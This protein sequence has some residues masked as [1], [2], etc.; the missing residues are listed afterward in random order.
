MYKDNVAVVGIEPANEPWQNINITIVQDY[1][2]DCYVIV[3]EL[4]PSWITLFH[5]SFRFNLATWGQFAQ[6]CPNY[7]IDTHIYQAWDPAGTPNSFQ[8]NACENAATVSAMEAVGVPVVVGEWSLAT[9]NCAL[10]LNGYQ[11]NVPGYPVIDCPYITCPVSYMD[12]R[13]EHAYLDPTWGPEITQDPR[14]TGE[15]FVSYG[16]CP[17]DQ[18]WNHSD[19]VLL[20]YAKLF[21][22]DYSNHGQFMWNFRTELEPRWSY[23]EATA[24]GWLPKGPFTEETHKIMLDTCTLLLNPCTAPCKTSSETESVLSF[25][26][27]ANDKSSQAQALFAFV[28][29]GLSLSICYAAYTIMVSVG[30]LSNSFRKG[31]GYTSLAETEDLTGLHLQTRI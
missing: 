21:A 5:D 15:S 4:A 7:A 25:V 19:L 31:F 13:N 18:V 26:L 8:V 22:F 29:L 11:D 12:G 30:Y 27:N 14:G 17:V 1:Y 6:G 24:A 28:V 20:G 10:W 23:L 9:D 16:Q 3:R 2:W